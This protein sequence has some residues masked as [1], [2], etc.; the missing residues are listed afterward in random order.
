MSD[1]LDRLVRKE[2]DLLDRDLLARA[3]DGLAYVD[4]DRARVLL[5]ADGAASSAREKMIIY[6]LG[7]KALRAVG[8]EIKEEV[9]PKEIEKEWRIPGGTVRPNLR[10]LA[11]EGVVAKREGGYYV[12]VFNLEDAAKV[13]GRE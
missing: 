12:P 3:L 1:P 2:E 6:L 13:L 5:T 8:S 11:K 4:K 9:E 10:E 7:R